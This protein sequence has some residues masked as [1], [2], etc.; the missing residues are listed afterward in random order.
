MNIKDNMEIPL[1]AIAW[2]IL[3]TTRLSKVAILLFILT[4]KAPQ[5]VGS[6]NL[7]TILAKADITWSV[8]RQLLQFMESANRIFCLVDFYFLS[9]HS[10]QTRRGH[11]KWRLRP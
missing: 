7:K 5:N 3:A 6:D 8:N 4:H 9:M 10:T 2:F 1:L 11:S